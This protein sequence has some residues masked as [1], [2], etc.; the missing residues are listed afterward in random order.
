MARRKISGAPSLSADAILPNRSMMS[1][2]VS[3]HS[4]SALASS[5]ACLS[6]VA[7]IDADIAFG[8]IAGPEPGGAFAFAPNLETDFAV[9]RFQLLFQRRFG[10]RGRQTA[11]ADQ[12]VLQ[13]D[14]DLG[15]IE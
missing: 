7:G 9:L 6:P 8:E 13:V 1:C 2:V 4:S 5:S 3:A 14:I 15:G 11:A 12:R 10:E